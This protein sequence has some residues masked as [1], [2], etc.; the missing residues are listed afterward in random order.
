VPITQL[1][2]PPR[3][4]LTGWKC[5]R[6]AC[7]RYR[8]PAIRWA[9]ESRQPGQPAPPPGVPGLPGLPAQISPLDLARPRPLRSFTRL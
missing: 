8:G 2:R 6:S 9:R 7:Y 5:P 1:G 4:L 3:A